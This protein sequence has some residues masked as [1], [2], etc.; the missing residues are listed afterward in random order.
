MVR[1]AAHQLSAGHLPQTSW[2]PYLG[3]GSPQFLHYQSLPATL[4]GLLGLG[5]GPDQAFRWTLYVLI[6][7]WP[8]SIYLSAR[9][10][11]MPRTAAAVSAAVSPFLA[12]T[13]G[14]GYEQKAYIWVGFG[15]WA[16]LWAAFTLPLAWGSTWRAVRGGGSVALAAFFT[17]ITVALHFE[18]GY[19][20]ILAVLLW[21]LLSPS[22]AFVRA[23]RAVVVL[24]GTFLLAAWVVVPLLAQRNWAAMN[25]ILRST[26]LA[27]GYGATRVGGWLITGDLL[28]A[29]RIPIVTVLA[30][31]GLAVCCERWRSDENGRALVLILIATLLLS[32]GRRTFGPLVDL[33]PGSRDIFFRRF[34]MGI[35]LSAL[36]LA[37]VGF[38]WC[39]VEI[40]AAIRVW[41]QR[42]LRPR[43]SRR[44]SYAC[45]LVAVAA[46]VGLLAP[47]V[48]QL[49]RLDQRNAAAIRKQH[50]ADVTDGARVD[51]LLAYVRRAGGGRVYAG[52][53]SNWGATLRVGAVPVY[54][55]L[56]AQDVD[57]IGNTMRT[58]SLMTNPERQFNDRVLSGYYLLGIRYLMMPAGH[59]PPVPAHEVAQDGAYALWTVNGAGY[60]HIGRVIGAIAAD[61]TNLGAR[62]VALL[63]SP[64]AGRAQ[65]VDVA[66]GRG[67]G[68]PS[69]LPAADAMPAPGTLTDASGA[70]SAGSLSAA[71]QMK[72]PGVLVLSAS[73]DPGW[74]VFLDGRRVSAEMI[75]PALVGVRVPAGRHEVRF[76]Y[77]GYG[78]Y[79]LLFVLAGVSLLGLAAVD[80]RERAR[81]RLTSIVHLRVG[82]CGASTGLSAAPV[83]GTLVIFSPDSPGDITVTSGGGSRV[84]EV[85]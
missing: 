49:H 64:L 21:P 19:L 69:A 58:A 55:Y 70:P 75:A 38:H 53:S 47:A 65:Y 27:Q 3:L 14:I 61:R 74:K 72:Q 9:M 20:A 46:A 11:D 43:W 52:M 15:V 8:I 71:V 35:Q 28:D 23:R 54:K 30:A 85:Q 10:F 13:V 16:Q 36:L 31:A 77:Y 60:F 29:G 63:H 37:G 17:A 42:L 40:A 66:Y 84:S 4:T 25:E 32:F 6:C 34:M 7:I 44:G 67:G 2:F 59:S 51:R 1:F 48:H 12:S 50:Q 83:C 76:R 80:A 82:A 41:P 24:G 18:T 45:G 22:Q 73:F 79:P 78:G 26:S 33:I 68:G 81:R 5:I 56:E 39:A 62:S 57:E